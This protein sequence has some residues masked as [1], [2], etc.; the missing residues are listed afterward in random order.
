MTSVL[1]S[2][3]CS[4]GS[5]PQ[6]LGGTAPWRA[7]A[8]NGGLGQ[9]PQRGPGAELLVRGSG[10]KAPLKLKHFWLLHVQW[11]PQ[12]CPLFET[13]ETQR[14]QIFMLPLQKIMGGHETEGGLEQNWGSVPPSP[15]LKP[16]LDMCH[17]FYT[18]Y[19]IYLLVVYFIRVG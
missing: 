3:M 14:H 12:I 8:Y 16:P 18:L 7:R 11:K 1:M 19:Q 13:L 17:N 15:G 9:S 6:N 5:S 4:G 2:D 10:S